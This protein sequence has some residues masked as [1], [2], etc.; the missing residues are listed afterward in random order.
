MLTPEQLRDVVRHIKENIQKGQSHSVE[1]SIIPITKKFRDKNI[2]TPDE[3]IQQ[4]VKQFKKCRNKRKYRV[5]YNKAYRYHMVYENENYVVW[6]NAVIKWIWKHI[7][8][9]LL[10]GL[11]IVGAIVRE[12]I[13][14]LYSQLRNKSESKDTIEIKNTEE[15]LKI[16]KDSSAVEQSATNDS[17]NYTKGKE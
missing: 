6:Y 3:E 16:Q 10:F 15:N 9:L 17:I 8:L 12:D 2:P 14:K 7:K 4:V 11:G 13:M 5:E 1:S